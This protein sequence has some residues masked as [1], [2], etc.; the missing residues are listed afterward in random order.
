MGIMAY[1]LGIMGILLFQKKIPYSNKQHLSFTSFPVNVI[2]T[3][4]A[5]GSYT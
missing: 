2:L 1:F 3:R 4:R 5:D